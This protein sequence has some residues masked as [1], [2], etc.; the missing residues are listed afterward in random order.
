M[1]ISW[2]C[3]HEISPISIFQLS[4]ER[5]GS[6]ALNPKR[7]TLARKRRGLTMRALADFVG[8][9]ART[10]SA[11]EHGEFE[12]DDSRLDRVS[13]VLNVPRQFFFGADLDEPAPEA[14]SF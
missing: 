11:W 7:I 8:V 2:T 4:A 5:M 1:A 13:A 3:L 10:V 9:E 14:T 12:P 6:E